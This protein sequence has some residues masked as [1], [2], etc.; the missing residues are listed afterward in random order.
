MCA[1]TW[2]FNMMRDL[3]HEPPATLSPNTDILPTALPRPSSAPGPPNYPWRVF[4]LRQGLTD[5]MLGANPQGMFHS[6]DIASPTPSSPGPSTPA[7]DRVTP[8]PPLVRSSPAPRTCSP[9]TPPTNVHEPA[10]HS[11]TP[12][13][14]HPPSAAVKKYGPLSWDYHAHLVWCAPNSALSESWYIVLVGTRIGVFDNLYVNRF[15]PFLNF[16]TF[17][18]SLNSLDAE[19]V[20]LGV[21]DGR[22]KGRYKTSG[23]AL[24]SFQN[25]MRRGNVYILAPSMS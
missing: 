3:T 23:A 18:T 2:P 12:P 17:L 5:T 22:V 4:Q 13:F 7:T 19:S 1:A 8:H 6:F 15:W 9:L 24:R 11:K 10:N 20:S 25:H 16:D 21:L 14:V